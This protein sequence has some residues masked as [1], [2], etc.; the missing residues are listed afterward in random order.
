MALIAAARARTQLSDFGDGTAWR[1]NLD[2]LAQA[3][4]AEAK[5]S[6]LGR[7]IAH[8]QLVAHLANRLRAQQL[9]RTHP[10]IL[11]QPV[12]APIV[13]LG[14]MRS[15]TTRVQRLL[16]CDPQFSHTRFFESWNPLPARGFDDRRLRGW[17]GLA[18]ARLLNPGFGA[19]HPT[20]AN[21]PD[22]EIGLHAFSFFGGSYEAQ[23]RI[24][25][26]VAHCESIDAR[27]VYAEFRRL[28]QTLAWLRGDDGLRPLILKVPQFTQDLPA[29]IGA[30]P[31]ARLLCLSRDR[32]A[33]AASSASLV[34][35]Q[36]EVQSDTVDPRWIT[37]EWDRK[38][39]LRDAR[40][41]HARAELRHVP[42]HDIAFRDVDRDWA[43]EMR[44]V[45]AF[46][47]RDLDATVL[48]RMA[49]YMGGATAHRAHRYP[50]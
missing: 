45:Y 24:P 11:D 40:V 1:I 35:N 37:R 44:K 16:A 32:A 46:L 18:I 20:G 48:E 6:P 29:L 33:L 25:T 27:P 30:F 42:Q 41:Q 28:V 5:L 36:M 43:S 19:I 15:G 47:D 10:E 49:R 22:E 21:A 8:G 38:N 31:D 3:L 4:E 23:W 7:V 9:W 50:A 26:F 2:V 34:R 39:A 17:A 12:T 13:V 14:Q